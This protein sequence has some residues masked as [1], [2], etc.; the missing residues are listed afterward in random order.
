MKGTKPANWVIWSS[1]SRSCPNRW[2]ANDCKYQHLKKCQKACFLPHIS[3]GKTAGVADITSC[4][5]CFTPTFQLCFVTF[6]KE[7]A[8]INYTCTFACF[9]YLIT[10]YFWQRFSISLFIKRLCSVF[11]SFRT[12]FLGISDFLWKNVLICRHWLAR[13]L[14][15]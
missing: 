6:E 2:S 15:T 4:W 7:S 12:Y 8:F 3:S 9:I 10:V 14:Q 5:N 11:H 1:F 13:K